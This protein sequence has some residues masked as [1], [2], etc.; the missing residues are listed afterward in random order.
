MAEARA[1]S[2][3]DGSDDGRDAERRLAWHGAAH[4]CAELAHVDGVV[5]AVGEARAHVRDELLAE[6]LVRLAHG[7][8][9]GLALGLSPVRAL[10]AALCVGAVEEALEVQQLRV[11]LARR[12]ARDHVRAAARGHARWE[13][14][15]AVLVRRDKGG[16]AAAHFAARSLLAH[17]LRRV[18]RL[19][20]PAHSDGQ[21]VVQQHPVVGL[22]ARRARE[23]RV[24]A[25]HRRHGARE[26]PR[27]RALAARGARERQRR[28]VAEARLVV[29]HRV[30]EDLVDALSRDRAGLAARELGRV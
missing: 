10:G 11:Q 13:E 26:R 2:R 25:V 4:E 28:H 3:R 8:P 24:L 16:E 23:R 1:L 20:C 9:R 19:L 7:R 14:R 18:V 30:A 17:Q 22:A 27:V 29:L 15:L 12:V 5:G 21:L 6:L